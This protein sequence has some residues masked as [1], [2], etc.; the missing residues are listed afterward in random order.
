[1]IIPFLSKHLS[2]PHYKASTVTNTTVPAQQ[3]TLQSQLSNIH[4]KIIEA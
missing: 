4:C 1:M 3:N 2:S